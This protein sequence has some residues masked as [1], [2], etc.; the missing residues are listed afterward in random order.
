VKTVE[1]YRARL[2][3]K[4]NLRSGTELTRFAIHWAT[5]DRKRDEH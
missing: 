2:K 3:D 4:M 5:E 1:S